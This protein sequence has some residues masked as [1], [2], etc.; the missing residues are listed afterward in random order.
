M[1]FKKKLMLSLLFFMTISATVQAS[2]VSAWGIEEDDTLHYW[3]H[4]EQGNILLVD[5]YMK[6]YCDSIDTGGQIAISVETDFKG[7][8]APIYQDNLEMTDQIF[9]GDNVSLG[10]GI[11]TRYSIRERVVLYPENGLTAAAIRWNGFSDVLEA[12]ATAASPYANFSSTITDTSFEIELL[13]NASQDFALMERY[14]FYQ[15]IEFTK[16]GVLKYFKS[17]ELDH[18]VRTSMQ[19]A[20]KVI[21]TSFPDFYGYAAVCGILF[22]FVG[23]ICC[24]A[25]RK[26][27]KS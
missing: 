16:S 17:Y 12:I 3:L 27:P 24:C 9:V 22:L 2:A 14:T 6:I 23:V 8:R 1:K 25:R 10:I 19:F 7:G 5:G 11:I 4:G 20:K 26:K 21:P 13:L 18:G 15:K